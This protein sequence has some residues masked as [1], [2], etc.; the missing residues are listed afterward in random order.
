MNHGKPLHSL[1]KATGSNRVGIQSVWKRLFEFGISCEFVNNKT[2][3][4]ANLN[5]LLFPCVVDLCERIVL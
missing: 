4:E 3:F 5:H 1:N 2:V